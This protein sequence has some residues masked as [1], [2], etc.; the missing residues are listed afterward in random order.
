M[1]DL[2]ATAPDLLD[3][4]RWIAFLEAFDARSLMLGEVPVA[5]TRARRELASARREAARL[6]Y[7]AVEGESDA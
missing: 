7:P 2:A 3:A 4:L 1:T 5:D 6:I